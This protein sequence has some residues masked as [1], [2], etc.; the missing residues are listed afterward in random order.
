MWSRSLVVAAVQFQPWISDKWLI[1]PLMQAA[2]QPNTAYCINELLHKAPPF[3]TVYKQPCFLC[4]RPSVKSPVSSRNIRSHE[5]SRWEFWAIIKGPEQTGG[6]QWG[7]TLTLALCGFIFLTQLPAAFYYSL[8][9]YPIFIFVWKQ[10]FYTEIIPTNLP[11][12]IRNF[13]LIDFFKSPSSGV[14]NLWCYT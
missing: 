14:F 4:C 1:G 13:Q 9:L 11:C 2:Y 10:L 8:L 3:H 7:A 6:T 5:R 12:V